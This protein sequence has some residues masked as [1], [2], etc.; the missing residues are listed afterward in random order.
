VRN[1]GGAQAGAVGVFLMRLPNVGDAQVVGHRQDGQL[2]DVRAQYAVQ[3]QQLAE[4]GEALRQRR[5]VHQGP[6]ES[7]IIVPA[8]TDN[9]RV[10]SL[11]LRRQPVGRIGDL[12]HEGLPGQSW[13]AWAYSAAIVL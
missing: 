6:E 13:W 10:D 5:V 3:T 1:Q 9:V 4:L 7:R 8:G 12:R 11:R 2:P